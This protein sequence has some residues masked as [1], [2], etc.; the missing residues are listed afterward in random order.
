MGVKIVEF[1]EQRHEIRAQDELNLIEQYKSQGYKQIDEGQIYHKYTLS[2]FVSYYYTQ[3]R[4]VDLSALNYLSIANQVNK[5]AAIRR[6][7]RGLRLACLHFP[8]DKELISQDVKKVREDMKDKGWNAEFQH[9]Y[10]L[11]PQKIKSYLQ[12]RWVM[13]VEL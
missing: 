8:D 6:H 3:V 11:L 13:V 5:P 12:G 10:D 4:V 9:Q 2:Q 1:A 7:L